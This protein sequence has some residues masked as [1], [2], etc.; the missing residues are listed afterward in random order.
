MT[1][2]LYTSDPFDPEDPFRERENFFLVPENVDLL[3]SDVAYYTV[4]YGETVYFDPK[5]IEA[6]RVSREEA[7]EFLTSTMKDGFEAT[8]KSIGRGI[9]MLA[10]LWQEAQSVHEQDRLTPEQLN[11]V[12]DIAAQIFRD[13]GRE[14]DAFFSSL[15]AKAHGTED[16]TPEDV[17]KAARN[18]NL[19]DELVAITREGFHAEMRQAAQ[20]MPHLPIDMTDINPAQAP[21]WLV[22]MH[23]AQ[24]IGVHPLVQERTVIGRKSKHGRADIQIHGAFFQREHFLIE[25]VNHP[26]Y[27]EVAHMVVCAVDDNPEQ[28]LYLNGEKVPAIQPYFLYSGDILRVGHHFFRYIALCRAYGNAPNSTGLTLKNALTTSLQI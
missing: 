8:L 23:N 6:F 7:H 12:E 15:L 27:P 20:E 1:H 24:Q 28:A 25:A 14:S 11:Q 16:M 26:H 13:I 3:P 5:S 10:G 19:M 4:P 17:E 9:S 18:D 2:T 22:M 21:Y